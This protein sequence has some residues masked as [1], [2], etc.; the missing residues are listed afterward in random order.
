MQVFD[1]FSGCGGT[2][3]GLQQAGCEIALG[4]DADADAV[5]SFGA[6]FKSAVIL[7]KDMATLTIGEVKKQLPSVFPKNRPLLIAACAPCQ[8]FSRLKHGTT[9]SDPRMKLLRSLFQFL[10]AFKPEYIFIENVPGICAGVGDVEIVGE[11]EDFLKKNGYVYRSEIV[12]CASFGVPQTRR[13]FILIATRIGKVVPWPRATH[14]RGTPRRI[15]T[16]WKAIGDYPPIAAGSKHPRIKNHQA[17]RLSKKNLERIAATPVNGSRADWPS[18]L[19]LP[20]HD[21]FDGFTDVY[22]RLRKNAL[23][24]AM[25]TRCISLSNGRFGHPVQNRAIS[26]R[27]AATLQTFPRSFVFEGSLVSQAR[28]VGNAVPVRLACCIGRAIQKHWLMYGVPD[29]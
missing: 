5:A 18:H 22:G 26:V 20:C 9:D 1:F 10:A 2:A 14:G 29:G 7:E 21:G 27:E 17:A 25:T 23:A 11:L 12:N 6:N 15:K 8:P 13:R 24:P 3:A 19:K 28:Q 4:V 16:V